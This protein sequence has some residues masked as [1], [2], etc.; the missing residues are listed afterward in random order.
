MCSFTRLQNKYTKRGDDGVG[1][2]LTSR[3]PFVF[4]KDTINDNR[5]S[6]PGGSH[7]SCIIYESLTND[8]LARP[9]RVEGL[10]LGVGLG[11]CELIQAKNVEDG[12][13]REKDRRRVNAHDKGTVFI[14]RGDKRRTLCL[15]RKF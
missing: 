6:G 5:H 13:G 9:R 1:A 2:T 3:S 8:L 15:S 7:G 11:V 14:G 4:G 10:Q 12:P